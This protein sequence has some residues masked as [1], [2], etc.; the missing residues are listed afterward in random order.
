MP[1]PLDCPDTACWQA[2]LD[3]AVSAEERE[4]CE[5]HLESCPACQER[6]DR[7]DR[8]D[9]ELLGRARRVGDPTTAPPD[10]ALVG[11]LERLHDGTSPERPAPPEPDDLYFLRPSDQPGILGVLGDYEVLEVIGQ[12]GMGV[13]LKALDPGLNRFVAIKVMAAAVAGSATARRRF[14]R[15]AQAAAAV[16]H[17]HVVPVYCVSEADSLPYLVMQYVAGES[18]QERIDHAGPLETEEAVRIG[19][20]AAA[21]LAAAHAQGL[22]HRDI[23]PANLLLENGVARVK[24]TD[25]GLARMAD[26]VGLTRD[27]VVAGTPEYMAPEQARGEPVDHRADLYSL[28]AVLYACC[29]GH[30]PFRGPSAV[31]VLRRV[32]DEAPAPVRAR[33]PRVPTWLEALIARLMAKDPAERFQS[34]AEVAA[35]LEGYLAHLRQPATNP[36]PSLPPAPGGEKPGEAARGWLM[37]VGGLLALVLV[38]AGLL[39]ARAL[40]LQ[41]VSPAPPST[42]FYQDFRGGQAPAPPLYLAGP[43]AATLTRPEAGG[44]RVTLPRDRKGQERVGLEMPT[45]I[46]GD[47]EITAGYEILQVEQPVK[48]PHGVAFS[49]LVETD[50]PRHDVVELAR[51]TR[52]TE[53]EVYNCARITTGDDGK[54]KYQHAFPP[55]SGEKGR[56]RLT[57]VGR[58]VTLSAAEGEAGEFQELTRYDLGPEDV[59]AVSATGFTGYAP[60]LLDLRILDFRLRNTPSSAAVGPWS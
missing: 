45:R 25:F 21:G 49:L 18:L 12:G 27:G 37:G 14:T 15:E 48:G 11:I 9:G 23:K 26:D 38:A 53:G 51:A 29:T 17:D 47:F 55:A 54:R 33:N 22:I 52:G 16:C 19:M 42:E 39:A 30:P 57:R 41:V 60:N 8:C 56:L 44:F 28:G 50:T 31:A 59:I 4:R 40:L 6:L 5:R 3:G 2:L 46:K 13:V 35:L 36:A 20:Q 1:V 7:A 10:P 24:I 32:S 34:A 43:D 58:E